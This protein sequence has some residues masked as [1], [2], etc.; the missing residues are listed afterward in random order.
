MAVSLP[1]FSELKRERERGRNFSENEKMK[2]LDIVLQYKDVIENKKTDKM[3]IVIK[4]NYWTKIADEYNAFQTTGLREVK[5]LKSLYEN[6]K[7][8]A[9]R[10]KAR[11]NEESQK[12]EAYSSEMNALSLRVLNELSGQ[13]E[14]VETLY[15]SS[16][17][18]E[19]VSEANDPLKIDDPPEERF[20]TETSIIE[21]PVVMIR[22]PPRNETP[23]IGAGKRRKVSEAN[24]ALEDYAKGKIEIA[25]SKYELL[26]TEHNKR[27]KIL[28]LEEETA[29]LKLERE[30][31]DLEISKMKLN[32]EKFNGL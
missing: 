10:D 16:S 25:Q 4:S 6:L 22:E 5:T 11:E 1:L 28:H 12:T 7:M 27:M 14:P 8:K 26:L 31:I 19:K 18:P 20:T 13:F 29:K 24:L 15:D 9:R 23:T 30:K 17:E 3:S 2:F 21:E 32:R